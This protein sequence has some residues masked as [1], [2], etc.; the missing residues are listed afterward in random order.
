LKIN[1]LNGLALPVFS[2]GSKEK[3]KESSRFLGNGTI[4][5][6]TH[7]IFKFEKISSSSFF[8]LPPVHQDYFY[9]F[10]AKNIN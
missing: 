10:Y 6:H 7:T 5:R 1:L 2:V 3:R 4:K 8:S 9:L